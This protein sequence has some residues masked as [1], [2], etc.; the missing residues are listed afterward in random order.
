V[1]IKIRTIEKNEYPSF[2]ATADYIADTCFSNGMVLLAETETGIPMGVLATKTTMM[3]QEVSYIFV[4]P[5]FRRRGIA[6]ALFAKLIELSPDITIRI[7]DQ[8]PFR[9][10]LDALV[11]KYALE[12]DYSACSYIADVKD[13]AD[14]HQD[15][16]EK[17]YKRIFDRFLSRGYVLKRFEECENVVK[18]IGELVGTEFE[19]NT[20]PMLFSNYDPRY[21]YCLLRDNQPLAFSL[22]ETVGD[23]A[24]FHLLSRAE[25]SAPGAFLLPLAQTFTD[26]VADGF[27]KVS[28]VIYSDNDRMRAL[29]DTNFITHYVNK[30]QPF[31]V[32]SKKTF[33]HPR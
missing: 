30:V 5:I 29:S 19:Y 16:Y 12:Y 18:R 14:L 24:V 4:K 31:K 23:M 27:W 7:K 1:G 2:T 26:L 20:N 13:N 9:E 22:I 3:F 33:L 21:S 15:M 10:A 11:K 8:H 32:F 17:R 6:T 25:H 28:F